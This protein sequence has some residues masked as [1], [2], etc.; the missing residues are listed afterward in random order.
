MNCDNCPIRQIHTPRIDD[1][2]ATGLELERMYV[3][4]GCAPSRSSF[5]S[6]RLPIHVTIAND[7]NGI[8]TPTHGMPTTMTG[9][10]SKLKEANYATYDTIPNMRM[11]TKYI[12]PTSDAF[13]FLYS[14][15]CDFNRYL[16]GKWDVGFATYA[17]L[18]IN[19]GYDYFYGYLG[20]AISYFGSEAEDDCTKYDLRNLFI[21]QMTKNHCLIYNVVICI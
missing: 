17:H 10:A 19:K 9:I 13:F 7:D 14:I 5:Q 15:L 12:S 18:P 3:Y 6:G 11:C 8:S 1:L 20:K 21:R 4:R 16:I 2:A